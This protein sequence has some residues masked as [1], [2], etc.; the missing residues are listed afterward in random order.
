[1][2][3]HFHSSVGGVVYAKGFLV[4]GVTPN[5]YCSTYIAWPV[6]LT[7]LGISYNRQAI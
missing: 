7:S 5:S 1:M 3:S 6:I 2:K 4:A